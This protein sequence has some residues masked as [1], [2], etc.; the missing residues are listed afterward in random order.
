MLA[1]RG[2]ELVDS[3]EDRRPVDARCH[4]IAPPLGSVIADAMRGWFDQL[5]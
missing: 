3:A 2:L 1:W 5:M 4:L